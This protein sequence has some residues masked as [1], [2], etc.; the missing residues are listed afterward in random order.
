M[1]ATHIAKPVIKVF[2]LPAWNEAQFRAC[3]DRLVK[4]AQS[5]TELH[6]NGADDLIILFS[7]DAMVYGVGAVILI[8]VAL[9]QHLVIDNDVETKMA[10]AMY[11][12]MQ[13][14]LPDAYIQC[15]V[16][17]FGTERGYRATG[18]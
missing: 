16:Y 11:A 2:L 8:E 1:S 4:A 3:F 17:S 18:M 5:V 15:G 10:N 13:G 6:V 12:V 7:H 14:L 9:P